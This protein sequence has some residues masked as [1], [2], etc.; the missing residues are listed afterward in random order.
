MTQIRHA[1][2]RLNWLETHLKIVLL[3][4]TGLLLAHTAQADT[5]GNTKS[6]YEA[7]CSTLDRTHIDCSC[8][9]KRMATFLHVSPSE[10]FD[11][12]TEASYKVLLGI[13]AD[14]ASA[15]EAAFGSDEKL[16]N[17]AAAYAPYGGHE[18]EYE[19]GCVIEGAAT[20]PLQSFPSDEI[21]VQSF[22]ACERSTGMTR[23]CQC[24]TA[25]RANVLTRHEFEADFLSFADYDGADGSSAGLSAMRA[26]KMRLT[27]TAYDALTISAREKLAEV[28][29]DDG[30]L[31][32]SNRCHAITYG[33]DTQSGTISSRL[34]RDD[35]ERAGP[36]IGFEDI[37]VTHAAPTA[38]TGADMM[39]SI[40]DEQ[41][42][43]F[44]AAIRQSAGAE[45]EAQALLNSAELSQIK[46]GSDLPPAASVV[47][48]GCL[49]EDGRSAAYCACFAT[50]FESR[51][52]ATMS[53]GGKRMTAMMLVGSGL[54]SVE[55]AQIA[56][57]ATNAEQMEA[58]MTFPNL[59][60]IPELCETTAQSAA[61]DSAM[62]E[63]TSV[64]ERYLA[65]CELQHGD[66]AG[67]ICTCAADHFESSL[68]ENEWSMLIDIQVAE[69]KG[70]DDAFAQYAS[71]LGLTREEAEQAI[72]SNPRLMQSMMGMGPA[73]MTSGF[74]LNR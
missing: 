2:G 10:D 24:D 70:E 6:K 51:I 72:M 9:G 28:T 41:Q 38:Q 3:A 17:I 40:A 21:Y 49:G 4:I 37:D 52:P 11:R 14:R 68:N 34:A 32:F 64:R 5:F 7:I 46:D 15:M 69:L 57:N 58:A 43:A 8:V 22:E 55:S 26:A 61:V 1:V 56:T 63:A 42:A 25:A 19:E 47:E 35:A 18:I 30:S 65:M 60:D 23:W 62:G 45:E 71:N 73:C 27:P 66:M 29:D 39:A 20:T 53:E 59:T 54:P 44:D 12:M 36:P 31:Y 13:P 33:E 67:S 74:G 50:E 48:R 16:M